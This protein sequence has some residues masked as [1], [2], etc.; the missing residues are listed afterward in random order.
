[1]AKFN[2]EVDDVIE[3]VQRYIRNTAKYGVEYWT[4]WKVNQ[5]YLDRPKTSYWRRVEKINWTFHVENEEVLIIGRKDR[6]IYV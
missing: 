5:K 6:N 2:M 1:M 3:L 4:L